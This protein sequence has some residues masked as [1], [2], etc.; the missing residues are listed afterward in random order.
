VENIRGQIFLAKVN[1]KE[2][3]KKYEYP[4]NSNIEFG[5]YH[6]GCLVMACDCSICTVVAVVLL[7]LGCVLSEVVTLPGHQDLDD[8]SR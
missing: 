7:V 8:S 1:A 2:A 4:L 6:G 3:R 5:A